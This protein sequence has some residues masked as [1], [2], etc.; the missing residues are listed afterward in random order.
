[1][2]STKVWQMFANDLYG[3]CVIAAV[4]NADIQWDGIPPGSTDEA[5]KTF[6]DWCQDCPCDTRTVLWKWWKKGFNGRKLW[7]FG[8]LSKTNIGQVRKAVDKFGCVLVSVNSF[9]DV[10]GDHMVLGVKT[11]DKCITCVSWAQEWTIPWDEY[12]AT[13]KQPHAIS[14]KWSWL[15]AYWQIRNEFTWWVFVA[16]LGLVL[17]YAASSVL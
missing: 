12:K 13:L 14:L 6:H 4:G 17:A 5:I 16:T 8:K 2:P 11:D 1:M 10:P 15:I 9:M 3:D 7:T